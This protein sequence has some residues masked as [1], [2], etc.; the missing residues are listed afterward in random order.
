MIPALAR[1]ADDRDA[2]RAD[3]LRRSLGRM[4]W[5]ISWERRGDGRWV[6]RLS[7]PELPETV[8]RCGRSRCEA[9]RRAAR[10]LSLR[11]GA[12][13]PRAAQAGHRP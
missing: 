9:A 2:R 3:R 6:A 5:L 13:G 10:V 8:A 4:R 11:R 7:C 1:W 12:D